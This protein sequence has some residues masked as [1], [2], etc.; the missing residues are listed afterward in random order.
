MT[1]K[2]IL[3]TTS[4]FCCLLLGCASVEPDYHVP[5]IEATA[6]VEVT[7][8]PPLR[9]VNGKVVVHGE[10]ICSATQARLA[11]VLT[12]WDA[13]GVAKKHAV[14]SVPTGRPIYVSMP[15]QIGTGNLKSGTIEGTATYTQPLVTFIPLAG[16]HYEIEFSQTSAAVFSRASDASQATRVRDHFAKVDTSCTVTTTNNGSAKMQFYLAPRSNKT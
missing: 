7:L 9:V 14:F 6:T 8:A 2:L 12:N 5:S 4:L 3:P 16:K 11:A 10:D 13:V 1:L 15:I